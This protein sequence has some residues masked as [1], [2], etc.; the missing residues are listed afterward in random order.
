MTESGRLITTCTTNDKDGLDYLP[1]VL[2]H[3]FGHALALEH[4]EVNDTLM[5]YESTK[6]IIKRDNFPCTS[7]AIDLG[8]CG[9]H[10]YDIHSMVALF[11]WDN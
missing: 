11:A 5:Y 7:T 2:G 9:I 4:H 10:P 3:E 8:M 1:H 6:A